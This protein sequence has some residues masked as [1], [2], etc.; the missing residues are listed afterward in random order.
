MGR[1]F[2]VVGFSLSSGS[3]ALTRFKGLGMGFRI[4]VFR[5]LGFRALGR[6]GFKALGCRYG[7]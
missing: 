3:S 2:R 7:I 6:L 5:V 4:T 1:A